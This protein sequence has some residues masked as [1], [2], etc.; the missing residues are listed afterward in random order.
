M[1]ISEVARMIGIT[2]KAIRLYEAK[3]LLLVGR[4]DNGYRDYS[5]E[6]IET[7]KMI[8]MLRSAG[9][10]IA[11]IKLYLF[12]VLTVNEVLD[13]R[14]KEIDRENGKN[15]DQYFHCEKIAEQI[16][17]GE[18]KINEI[19]SE[20]EESTT[21][22]YGELTV[23]I[24]I[25]T[26]T[27]SVAV[28]D[29]D[30][31]KQIDVYTV[32]HNADISSSAFS[33]Q[34][35]FTIINKAERLLE[36]ILNIYKN[37]ISIGI[38]GQM[39]G[40]V[41]INGDGEPVSN[42]IN[43]QDK[44]ADQAVFDGRSTCEEIK[45][46]TGEGIAT[47]YGIATHYYNMRNALVPKDAVGFCSIMDVLSMRLCGIKKAITHTS[48]AASFG[49]FDLENSCFM[50]E[51]LSMLGIDKELLPEV[52]KES[53]II[54]IWNGIPVSVAIGD[55]QASFLGSVREH[56]KSI[57]VNI[58]TGSQVSA[59][60]DFCNPGSGVE[61]RPL[62]EGKYLACGSA[63]C[64]GAAYALAERFFRSY[65]VTLGMKD[66][67]QY[68]FMN[69]LALQAYNNKEETLKVDTSFGGTRIDPNHRGSVEMIDEHNFTPAGLI[70]GIINGMCRELYE[71]CGSFSQTKTYI[72]ASGGAVRKNSV[73]KNVIGDT[74][75]MPVSVSLIKE[76]AAT[77]AALF[78]AFA[79]GKIGY[80]DGFSNYISYDK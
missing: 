44:R 79:A 31:K 47:G 62:I 69:A 53:K 2:Q 77:G 42:L 39:H 25:G 70:L 45:R 72:V 61:I 10:T 37:V 13:K 33:E 43:W 50:Y 59:V 5:E 3:G 58:G 78:A 52:T 41:Y 1:K 14:K 23:G 71:L 46:I 55:N 48:V 29:I 76:E 9:I 27:I 30:Q 38:T 40:I 57:L 18:T 4:E 68:P 73:L 60:S 74:F 15:T 22:S 49:L 63:L 16:A 21:E 34:S 66:A 7:L 51:K 65:A 11:D 19:I 56:E 80:T 6:D 8:K 20:T 67:S 26:T 75:G 35:V 12:G 24:D 32:Y 54:G 28:I 36:Y 64:G 17:K